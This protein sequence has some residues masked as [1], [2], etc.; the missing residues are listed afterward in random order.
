MIAQTRSL[1]NNRILI[2]RPNLQLP[3]N[4]NASAVKW[5]IDVGLKHC[6][7]HNGPEGWVHLAKVTSWS[8][9][10]SSNINLDH[11]SSSES[12][13]SI[14][15]NLNQTS[16]SPQNFN[17]KILTKPSFRIATKIQPHNFNQTSAT[18]Y[19]TNFIFNLAETSTSKS[20]TNFV[21]KVRT[22]IYLEA[23]TSASKSAPN[24]CQ[25]VS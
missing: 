14:N 10:R 6:Q 7:R 18:K 15:K 13:L 23:K 1:Q 21:L 25:H 2:F 4:R 24:C 17:F 20:S 22:K 12:R 3:V 5:R 19:G 11:I 16:A 9:I 8:H